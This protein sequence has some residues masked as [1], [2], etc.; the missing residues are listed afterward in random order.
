MGLAG[1]D[2]CGG[3]LANAAGHVVLSGRAGQPLPG[4]VTAA[5]LTGPAAAWLIAGRELGGRARLA[6]LALGGAAMP[7]VAL[8]ALA[9]AK[10]TDGLG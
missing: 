8:A 1:G 6:A 4:V 10:V 2:R 7:A 3:L 5:L 9:L